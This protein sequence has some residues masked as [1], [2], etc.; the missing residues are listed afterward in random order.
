MAGFFTGNDG[1]S[2]D[3]RMPHHRDFHFAGFDPVAHDLD[4]TVQPP[5]EGKPTV[6]QESP[7]IAGTVSDEGTAF[8][9][10]ADPPENT[11][12]GFR[13]VHVAFARVFGPNDYLA[14]FAG[15][16]AFIPRRDFNRGAVDRAPERNRRVL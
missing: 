13:I 7:A 11:P 14:D 16:R 5:L 1:S 2:T 8:A 15:S 6:G 10:D 4:L 3:R 9:A 12:R